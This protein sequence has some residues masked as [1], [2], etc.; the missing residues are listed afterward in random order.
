MNITEE[1]SPWNTSPEHDKTL[2]RGFGMGIP[3]REKWIENA[4]LLKVRSLFSA[5]ALP[6]GVWELGNRFCII[7]E[8]I[9]FGSAGRDS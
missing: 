5:S 6:I 4:S 1:G 9:M 8:I 7:S 3:C 2:W